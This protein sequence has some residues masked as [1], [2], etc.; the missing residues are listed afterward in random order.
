MATIT[1]G[2]A[3]GATEEVTAAKLAK[4]ASSITGTMTV[5]DI[6]TADILDLAV[7]NAKIADVSAVKITNLSSMPSGAGVIP[8]A[9]LGTGTPSS[10][11]YLRGDG[12]YATPAT[13][14]TGLTFPWPGTI[15]A[16]P[17]G[18]LFLNGA[19]VSR[20]TYA[21]LFAILGEIHGAG[22]G[23]N[24]FNLPDWRNVT[25]V[26]AQEDDAGIPKSNITGS[27]AASSDGLVPEHLHASGTLAV[28]SHTHTMTGII[29][30]DGSGACGPYVSPAGT[31]DCAHPQV[32]GATAPALS[33]STANTGTGTK[34]VPAH[35]VAVWIIKT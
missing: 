32:T 18:Y 6:A 20:T 16:I 14:P 13:I 3:F 21:S 25:L 9:N 22:D 27:L 10:S 19:A 35:K 7:T 30:G 33:G 26:G 28:A 5:T 29:L 1:P 31:K 17:S 8:A 11:T 15:A 23:V 2:Y 24:T 34:V 12:T 4:L